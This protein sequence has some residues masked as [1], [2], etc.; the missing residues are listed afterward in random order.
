MCRSISLCCNTTAARNPP[1]TLLK[2]HHCLIRVLGK[3][4]NS[5]C[6]SS[7]VCDTQN[8]FWCLGMDKAHWRGVDTDKTEV[9]LHSKLKPLRG[10]KYMPFHLEFT[11]V[12][13]FSVEDR[14]LQASTA[15]EHCF[16]FLHSSWEGSALS[17]G[18]FFLLPKA[19]TSKEW[20]TAV[21]HYKVWNR[22]LG[23]WRKLLDTWSLV[24]KL[25]RSMGFNC[26]WSL[27][28]KCLG[29][30]QEYSIHWECHTA[31]KSPIFL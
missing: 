27:I 21:Q 24:E 19:F 28:P 25:D 14:A 30:I 10:C 20:I 3:E 12:A 1:W 7:M 17:I 6:M 2:W 16:S 5:F 22:K 4:V 26:Y 15:K 31:L 18:S 13:V 23:K 8:L 29:G 11:V 9:T